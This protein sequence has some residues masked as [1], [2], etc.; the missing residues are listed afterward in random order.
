MSNWEATKSFLKQI[1]GMSKQWK[2]LECLKT[3]CSWLVLENKNGSKKC[4][5][6]EKCVQMHDVF[7]MKECRYLQT[8]ETFC[9]QSYT[10]TKS[11]T[12]ISTTSGNCRR[13]M[14][15][16]TRGTFYLTFNINQ[17]PSQWLQH[18]FHLIINWL[19]KF[20][21]KLSTEFLINATSL[22]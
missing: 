19:Y 13:S 7:S 16:K 1:P 22:I 11:R 5:P 12:L 4:S 8:L 18:N 20:Y 15:E 2:H 6:N 9:I 17:Q 14:A 10:P 3:D 21:I